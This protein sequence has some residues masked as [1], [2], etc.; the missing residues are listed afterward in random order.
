VVARTVSQR[1]RELAVRVALG[2]SNGQVIRLVL[3]DT[4]VTLV[5]GLMIGACGGAWLSDV[6]GAFLYGVDRQ[7]FWTV[8]VVA[9]LL[10]GVSVGAAAY[11]PARRSTGID[12][13]A[14]LALD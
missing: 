6:L 13:R 10:V 12:L 8:V 1:V 9:V 4:L 2:A 3:R 5:V 7:S 14:L 11:V